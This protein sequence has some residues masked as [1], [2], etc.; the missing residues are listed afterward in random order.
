[1]DISGW[2][3]EGAIQ[4]TF[5]EGTVIPGRGYKVIASNPAV[6]ASA[7]IISVMLRARSPIDL[8][9]AGEED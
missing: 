9:N 7:G 8:G 5:A 3:L 1:M 2:R 4:Y 6:L